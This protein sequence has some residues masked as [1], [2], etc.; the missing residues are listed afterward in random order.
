[1]KIEVKEEPG[2]GEGGQ[3]KEEEPGKGEVKEEEPSEVEWGQGY[4]KVKKENIE[5]EDDK[6]KSVVKSENMEVNNV[7]VKKEEMVGSEAPVVP[8]ISEDDRKLFVGGL[9]QEAKDL[10]IMEHFAY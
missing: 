5:E 3:M 1:M 8:G 6:V 10:D 4:I 2:E 9:H 7:E